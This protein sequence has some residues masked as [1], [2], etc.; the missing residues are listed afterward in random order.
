MR[1]RR[2]NGDLNQ[3]VTLVCKTI[4]SPSHL[5]FYPAAPDKCLISDSEGM[6]L[7]KQLKNALIKKYVMLYVKYVFS[8][9]IFAFSF[10]I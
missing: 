4:N 5:P 8:F 7:H 2:V 3:W 1:Q 10:F 9:F 6:T